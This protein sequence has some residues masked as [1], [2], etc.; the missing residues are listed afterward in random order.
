[1]HGVTGF[2]LLISNKHLYFQKILNTM[3]IFT[4]YSEFG[5]K[6]YK[7]LGRHLIMESQTWVNVL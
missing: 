5:L 7:N 4:W 3:V 1:M 2:F 6:E